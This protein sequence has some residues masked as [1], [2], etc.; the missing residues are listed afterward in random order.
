MKTKMMLVLCLMAVL[1]SGCQTELSEKTASKK[2]GIIVPEEEA[3]TVPNVIAMQSFKGN[4][5]QKL[6]IPYAVETEN[7]KIT[8]REILSDYMGIFY[9]L[10]NFDQNG[11]TIQLEIYNPDGSSQF[12]DQYSYEYDDNGAPVKRF[13]YFNGTLEGVY[14]YQY[15]DNGNL[16]EIDKVNEDESLQTTVSYRYNDAGYVTGEYSYASGYLI[17]GHTYEYDGKGNKIEDKFNNYSGNH[18]SKTTYGY[19]DTGKIIEQTDYAYAGGLL[20]HSEKYIYT[21][22]DKGNVTKAI[23]TYVEEERTTTA[24]YQYTYDEHDNWVQMIM[25]SGHKPVSLIERTLEYY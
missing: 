1:L 16:L 6:Q 17:Y 3:A 25:F 21:Y 12:T 22:D 9:E 11:K 7:G 4:V 14:L 23:T 8:K 20:F 19:D 24:T 15:D 5:K 13:S 18:D 10:Y 2:A